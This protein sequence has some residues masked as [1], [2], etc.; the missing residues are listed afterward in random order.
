MYDVCMCCVC[1]SCVSCV[2][3]MPCVSCVPCMPCALCVPYVCRCPALALV[4][5]HPT[6]PP[7]PTPP[8]QRR[9]LFWQGQARQK[10]GGTNRTPASEATGERRPTKRTALAP[11]VAKASLT[12]A[13]PATMLTQVI[14]V[15]DSEDDLDDEEAAALFVDDDD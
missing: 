13:F 3:C 4:P 5:S 9:R 1:M 7:I 11:P 15:D 2:P 6:P 14:N 10:G 12:P 8:D